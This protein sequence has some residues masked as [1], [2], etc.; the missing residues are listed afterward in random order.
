MIGGSG[1]GDVPRAEP[2]PDWALYA[3]VEDIERGAR[4]E[5]ERFS[6]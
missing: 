1:N 3:I 2:G 6:S 4:T 5:D